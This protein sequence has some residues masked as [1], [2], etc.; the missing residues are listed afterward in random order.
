MIEGNL[1]LDPCNSRPWVLTIMAHFWT[2]AAAW[3]L[4]Q[5]TVTDRRLCSR[6]SQAHTSLRSRGPG[7]TAPPWSSAFCW[8]PCVALH[9]TW[10][11]VLLVWWL[12]R[13]S[14]SVSHT[15]RRLSATAECPE[16]HTVG[17]L[18]RG[19]S[20]TLRV[21]WTDGL[22]QARWARCQNYAST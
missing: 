12:R 21:G 3:G 19:G 4:A 14:P 13:A 20:R 22:L 11:K 18:G 15:A 10:A 17:S 2:T 8:I 6:N 16:R 9:T 5:N 1:N 7:F